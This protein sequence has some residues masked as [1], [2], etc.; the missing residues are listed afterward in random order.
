V[1]DDGIVPLARQRIEDKLD[2]VV[3]LALRFVVDSHDE[4]RDQSHQQAHQSADEAQGRQQWQ[5]RS[6]ERNILEEF[7]VER[8]S[9]TK[10]DDASK[11]TPSDRT[12]TSAW[13]RIW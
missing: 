5:R 12:D 2:A 1:G 10:N 7:Q 4:F 3:G 13:Y 9:P 6:N 8:H 11:P